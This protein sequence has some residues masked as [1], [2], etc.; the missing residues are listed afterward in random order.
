MR[1][2]LLPVGAEAGEPRVVATRA[3]GLAARRLT[4]R[5]RVTWT[6]V[7]LACFGRGCGPVGLGLVRAHPGPGRPLLLGRT[8]QSLAAQLASREDQLRRQAFSDSLTGLANRRL[9]T[10]RVSEALERLERGDDAVAVPV[11]RP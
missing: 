7:A 3:S 9:F 8:R 5:L 11:V 6:W 2:V 10:D 1:L 4:G